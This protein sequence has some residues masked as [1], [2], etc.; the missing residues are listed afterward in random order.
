MDEAE[1][2]RAFL[3]RAVTSERIGT[4]LD[5]LRGA[6]LE[7]GPYRS[8]PIGL[9]GGGAHAS[10]GEPTVTPNPDGSFAVTL[11][12]AIEL[13]VRLGV[14]TRVGARASVDLLL[15]PRPARPLLIVI[16]VA[17]VTAA[18]VRIRPRGTGLAA[19]I[20][21]LRPLLDE[22][23]GILAGAVNRLLESTRAR[24]ARTFDIGWRLDGTRAEPP[25]GWDWLTDAEFGGEVL[26]RAVNADRVTAAVADLSGRPI[27][28][29][30]LPAGPRGLASVQAGGTVTS[31]EV[32][33]TDRG[34]DV[35]VRLG[36]DLEVAALG[37]HRYH[38]DVTFPVPITARPAPP[39]SIDVAVGPVEASAVA[40]E[41]IAH[42]ASAR[43][44][45]RVGSLSS[46]LARRVASA[47]NRQI[48]AGAPRT[49]DLGTRIDGTG[50]RRGPRPR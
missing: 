36:L 3:R 17:R 29:G 7:L 31:A 46:Q 27:A 37:R 23:G 32:V 10:L 42:S 47:A 34:H 5:R 1:F 24:S 4:A 33:T 20:A 38:A 16:D 26:R 8:G 2:G 44:L 15:T 50:R 22:T 35:A 28:I 13:S 6:R 41:L 14:E 39:L 11:P 45:A 30:P 9:A 40:V 19:P 25:A 12:A 49:F 48:A 18:D 21:L 43:L